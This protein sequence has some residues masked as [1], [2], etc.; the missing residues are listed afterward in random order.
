MDRLIFPRLSLLVCFVVLLAA[1]PFWFGA[2]RPAPDEGAFP[3]P[4]DL[5]KNRDRY[6]GTNVVV[7]GTVVNTDPKRIQTRVNGQRF[8]FE[9]Q[10][11][12]RPIT[13]GDS[14][15]VYGTLVDRDTILVRNS[16][17]PPAGGYRYAVVASIGGGIWVLVRLIRHWRINRD[18]LGLRPRD[19]ATHPYVSNRRRG[20]DDRDA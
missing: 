16:V 15:R 8:T 14:L 6:V 11:I 19:N 9:L 13:A 17:V 7:R 3:G 2:L 4:E 12:S 5:S 10:N 20:S 18:E 1:I